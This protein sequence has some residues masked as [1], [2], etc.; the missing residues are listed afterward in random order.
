VSGARKK[1]K[2]KATTRGAIMRTL[3][4]LAES[5]ELIAFSFSYSHSVPP[6]KWL[7]P[8]AQVLQWGVE[9]GGGGGMHLLGSQDST[10]T[11]TV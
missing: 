3:R 11:R 8:I 5:A 6:Q 9:G 4:K 1:E 2:A 10:R 7:E